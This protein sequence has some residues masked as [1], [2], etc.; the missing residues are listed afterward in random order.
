MIVS[1]NK[2]KDFGKPDS[3][4][5]RKINKVKIYILISYQVSQFHI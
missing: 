1:E 3:L 2:E 4:L 5:V